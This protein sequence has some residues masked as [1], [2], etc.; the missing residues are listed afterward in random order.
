MLD[1]YLFGQKIN[2]LLI[3][4]GR[5][6]GGGSGLLFVFLMLLLCCFG[7]GLQVTSLETCAIRELINVDNSSAH[8]SC[9]CICVVVY[10]SYGYIS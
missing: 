2:V 7:S 1:G 5:F 8:S 9:I 6:K 3:T 4:H 10:V